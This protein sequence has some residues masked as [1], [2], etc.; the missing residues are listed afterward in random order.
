MSKCFRSLFDTL[1]Q[2]QMSN[3]QCG[4]EVE[5]VEIFNDEIRDLLSDNLSSVYLDEAGLAG[6]SS[7]N[8]GDTGEVLACLELG[9]SLHRQCRE[10]SRAEPAPHTMFSLK[11]WQQSTTNTGLSVNKQSRL[12][13]IDLAPSDQVTIPGGGTNLGECLGCY[14]SYIHFYMLLM[15]P[16]R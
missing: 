9:G 7:V 8:C 15:I 14:F 6:V 1:S 16:R 4:L 10:L 13:F 11:L 5:Y 12:E 3:I 2:M